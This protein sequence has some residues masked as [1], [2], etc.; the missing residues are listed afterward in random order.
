MVALQILRQK[1]YK[2]TKTS[3][4]YS[5]SRLFFIHKTPVVESHPTTSEI[6]RFTT[7]Q[8]D[9]DEKHDLFLHEQLTH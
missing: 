7:A 5:Q 6:G 1:I 4:L 9:T 8:V 3:T 2:N